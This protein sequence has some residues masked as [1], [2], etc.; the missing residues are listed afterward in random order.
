[1][2]SIKKTTV[3]IIKTATL[4]EKDQATGLGKQVDIMLTPCYTERGGFNV[5]KNHSQWSV[6]TGHECSSKL[7]FQVVFNLD[8]WTNHVQGQEALASKT[9]ISCSC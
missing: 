5:G 8:L 7:T 2:R 9:T 3:H 4:W 6:L 1:M